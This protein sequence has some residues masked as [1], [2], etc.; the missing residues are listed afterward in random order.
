M[1]LHPIP[2]NFSIYEETFIFFFISVEVT[3]L[4]SVSVQFYCPEARLPR[5]PILYRKHNILYTAIRFISISSKFGICTVK[6]LHG[7]LVLVTFHPFSEAKATFLQHKFKF[8]L[9]FS[10]VLLRN[11]KLFILV[12]VVNIIHLLCSMC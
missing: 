4:C 12:S 10:T 6:G 7:I 9:Q 8:F 2:L 3:H 5:C 11:V 1:T